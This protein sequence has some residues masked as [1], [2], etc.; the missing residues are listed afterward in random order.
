MLWDIRGVLVLKCSLKMPKRTKLGAFYDCSS[1]FNSLVDVC[2]STVIKLNFKLLC[3]VKQQV[4]IS[5]SRGEVVTIPACIAKRSPSWR[6]L[7]G[8]KWCCIH[9]IHFWWLVPKYFHWA[10]VFASPTW[11]DCP[12]LGKITD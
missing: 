2:M 7:K 5:S 4:K 1:I 8:K 9:W 11:I 12:W 3:S 6:F 10:F